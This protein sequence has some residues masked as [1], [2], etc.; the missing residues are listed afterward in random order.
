MPDLATHQRG[1]AHALR[2]IDHGGD[3]RK[4]DDDGRA[5]DAIRDLFTTDAATSARRIA[6]YRANSIASATKALTGAYPVIREVVGGEFFDALARAHWQSTPSRS[7]DLGDYGD[8]FDAFVAGFEPVR[9]LPY[10][11]DVA[12]LEWAGHRAHYAA[13]VAVFDLSRLAAIPPERQGDLRFRFNPAVSIVGSRFPVDR[14]WEV[15]Q[16]GFDG[17]AG[18]D[19]DAG[20]RHVMVVRPRFRVLVR[21]LSSGAFGWIDAAARGRTLT[22]ALEAAFTIDP[23]FDLGTTLAEL[24]ADN[25]IIDIE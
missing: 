23:A 22:Q 20:P 25:T 16:P 1:F 21:R 14:I 15:N 18:V 8:A 13:D 24:I 17:D 12:R 2:A 11:P 7:G 5:D 10:L 6:I 9:E 3:G 4:R 19:L